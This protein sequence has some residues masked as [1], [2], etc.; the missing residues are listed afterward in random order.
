[1]QE[2]NLLDKS[3]LFTSCCL[4]ACLSTVG[5]QRAN[6]WT[7]GHFGPGNRCSWPLF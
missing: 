5:H 3:L 6:L 4:S 7:T 1:V 2:L